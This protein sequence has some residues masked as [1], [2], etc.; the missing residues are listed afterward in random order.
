MA[1]HQV[2]LAS[3]VFTNEKDSPQCFYDAFG[4]LVS[5]EPGETV[6]FKVMK[7]VVP[8]QE[9]VSHDYVNDDHSRPRPTRGRKPA[10]G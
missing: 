7:I 9:E 8:E 2:K 3:V 5:A 10:N 6:E 1:I 4:N